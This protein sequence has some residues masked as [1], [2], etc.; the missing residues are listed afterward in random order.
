MKR[1]FILLFLSLLVCCKPLP[2][3]SAADVAKT[4]V[5]T[6]AFA[7]RATFDVCKIEVTH[8]VR[9]GQSE[10][11]EKV[12]D[13][14]DRA[15]NAAVPAVGVLAD[16]VDRGDFEASGC[17]LE[18]AMRGLFDARTAFAALGVEMPQGYQTA[19][20]AAKMAVSAAQDAGVICQHPT[21]EF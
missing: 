17:P 18:D 1:L 16:M 4:T 13:S 8:L 11:A 14:C 2:A 19:L 12:A 20:D 3:L 10:K 21:G 7:A 6:M 9:T 5:V 15:L